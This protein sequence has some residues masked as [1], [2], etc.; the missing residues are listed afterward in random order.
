MITDGEK[1]HYLAAK[2]LSA[3]FRGITSNHNVDSYRLNCYHSYSTE[4]RLKKHQ[5][6]CNHNDYCHTEMPKEDE[7]ILKYNHG[8]KSLKVSFIIYIDLQC[9]QKV[10]GFCLNN[11]EKSYPERKPKHE[12]SVWAMTVKCLFYATKNKYDY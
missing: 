11:P 8:E 2:S 4:D 7:K 10:I 1:R 12:P 6:L 5:R 3:L 9:S